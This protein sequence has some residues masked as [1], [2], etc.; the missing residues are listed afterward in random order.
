MF[1]GGRAAWVHLSGRR[2]TTLIVEVG[3]R[4]PGI[5]IEYQIDDFANTSQELESTDL[6]SST[7]TKTP[8]RKLFHDDWKT[9]VKAALAFAG[10]NAAG[11]MVTGGFVLGNVFRNVPFAN[12]TLGCFNFLCDG[13]HHR[14]SLCTYHCPVPRRCDRSGRNGGSLFDDHGDYF[15]DCSANDSGTSRQSADAAARA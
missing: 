1:P 14:W 7:Q 12:Q 15:R 11:Y 4:F 8:L 13:C 2:N 3:Q 9:V 6:E 10:S 5:D